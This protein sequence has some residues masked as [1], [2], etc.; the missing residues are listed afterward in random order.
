MR[1]FDKLK[2]KNKR[3]LKYNQDDKNLFIIISI[4]NTNGYIKNVKLIFKLFPPIIH[5]LFFLQF[6]HQLFRAEWCDGNQSCFAKLLCRYR[7]H[8]PYRTDEV[9][10]SQCNL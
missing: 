5:Q 9:S 3:D 8:S 6:R 4:K 1:L 7:Q 10:T 2:R